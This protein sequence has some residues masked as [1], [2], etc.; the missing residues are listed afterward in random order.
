MVKGFSIVDK[1]EVDIFLEVPC[2]FYDPMDVGNLVSGSSVFS[3][4]IL[5][6]Q[7]PQA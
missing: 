2:H 7:L 5:E 3:K 6:I 1:E 4:Y